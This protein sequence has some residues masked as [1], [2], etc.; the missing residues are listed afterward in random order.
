M[1]AWSKCDE[2]AEHRNTSP[3]YTTQYTYSTHSRVLL[4]KLI[5]S[6]LVKKFPTSHGI[7]RF[8]TTFTSAHHLSLSSTRS[9]QSM[10]PHHTTWKSVL[11]LSSHLCLGIPSGLFPSG[12]PTKPCIHLCFTHTCYMPCQL[13]YS[14]F[15]H[16]NNTGWGV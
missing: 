1:S 3:I 7:R 9:I 13:H 6:Q 15:Y 2:A 10:P 4:E 12:L 14:G 11:I 5:G 16:P 8:I